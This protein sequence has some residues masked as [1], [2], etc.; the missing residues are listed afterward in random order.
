MR[1]KGFGCLVAQC[2]HNRKPQQFTLQPSGWEAQ[3]WVGEFQ[4]WLFPNLGS[5]A[6][7]PQLKQHVC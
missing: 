7:T 4:L 6:G 1:R 5:A 3:G 2:T